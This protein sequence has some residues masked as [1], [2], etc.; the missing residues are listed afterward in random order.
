[1]TTDPSGPTAVVELRFT[2]KANFNLAWNQLGNHDFVLY[3][4]D[5]SLLS[6]EAGTLS[7][8][9]RSAGQAIGMTSIAGLAAGKYHLVVDA[10]APGDEGSVAVH[11]SAVPAM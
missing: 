10:D 11:L 3:T 2:A 5:G 1:M 9:V 7:S 6:C 4:D 8:C